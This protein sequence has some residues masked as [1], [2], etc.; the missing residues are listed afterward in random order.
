MWGGRASVTLQ[1]NGVSWPVIQSVFSLNGSALFRNTFN[2]IKK[3]FRW[4]K[5]NRLA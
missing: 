4:P 2:L 1:L 5:T 3:V